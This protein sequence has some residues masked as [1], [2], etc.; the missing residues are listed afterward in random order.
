MKKIPT[1]IALALFIAAGIATASA[2]QVSLWKNG[3]RIYQT[4]T[5]DV[6]SI[7]FTERKST[8]TV[9]NLELADITGTWLITHCKGNYTSSGIVEDEWDYDAEA[10]F[11]CIVI[12]TDTQGPKIAYTGRNSYMWEED[13]TAMFE[14]IDG[15]FV[16]KEGGFTSFNI[17]EYKEDGT[18]VVEYGFGSN[19]NYE[20]F[21]DT[22]KR[23]SK[24]TDVLFTVNNLSPAPLESLPYLG[25]SDITGTWQI[26]HL[27][28]KE[29][30]KKNEYRSDVD[31][32]NSKDHF[33]FFPDGRYGYLEYSTSKNEW[34]LDGHEYRNYKVE[35]GVLR[36]D[37]SMLLEYDKENGTAKIFNV[38]TD[39]KGSTEYD[40]YTVK[41]VS[42]K[43][44]YITYTE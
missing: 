29:G 22:M 24:R 30:D 14:I 44:D 17:K 15:K 16:Y 19:G 26:T 7:T 43:T 40:I 35:N 25:Y 31:M 13:F 3:V 11:N 9:D 37:N 2:Q 8:P 42:T 34:H 33:V 38:F 36:I 41:R 18:I 5:A 10:D 27:K 21:T 28:K 23:I 6:D 39:K 1:I 4:S 12:G 32:S 20:R